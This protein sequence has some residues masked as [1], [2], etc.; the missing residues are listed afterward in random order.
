[1]RPSL[2]PMQPVQPVQPVQ[3]PH[4]GLPAQG[5]PALQT[6]G[7]ILL[8]GMLL[9]GTLKQ[10]AQASL[11]N[12][13]LA[14]LI[15]PMLYGFFFLFV[16]TLQG[17]R[18]PRT[19]LP[20]LFWAYLLCVLHII[21][22][23]L[24]GL[25]GRSITTVAQIILVFGFFLWIALDVHRSP[26]LQ[27]APL[28]I[29]GFMA[30]HIG[31]LAASGFPR[32][33][34]S[35]YAHSNSIG[36]FALFG[37]FFIMIGWQRA[38]TLVGK[39]LYA[40]GLLASIVLM[41]ASNSRSTWV[42]VAVIGLTY[43]GWGLIT[44]RRWIFWL[45]LT[46]VFV[47]IF[48]FV[49]GYTVVLPELPVFADLEE[50]VFEY[51]GKR[52]LSGRE[53]IW[54]TLIE[55]ILAQPLLGYGPGMVASEFAP[56]HFYGL[57]AHNLYLQVGLQVGLVG[58]ALVL[59]LLQSIWGIFWRGRTDAT[60]RLAG[61]FFIATLTHQMFEVALTQNNLSV[62]LIQWTIIG[63]GASKAVA[64]APEHPP[65]LPTPHIAGGLR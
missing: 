56:S 32:L 42:S 25:S 40:G 21:T 28:I 60:V 34:R 33:F 27:I 59:L 24:F 64:P 39:A 19:L 17:G 54:P 36:A 47:G 38:K 8:C 5:G 30:V 2:Q 10:A 58:L 35:F 45:Y 26:L 63:I 14:A 44:R 46:G 22:L 43:L 52:L 11:Q 65:A 7:T 55:A 13:G 20:F 61:A 16:H 48:L 51:T 9:V 57:S 1:M 12:V 53:E 18:L 37:A 31:V 23:L 62:G 15:L 4:Q 6:A 29:V 41:L 49:Y 3:P 50:L